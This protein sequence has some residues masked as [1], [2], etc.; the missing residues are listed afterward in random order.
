VVLL[1][2]AE[3][4]SDDADPHLSARG[5]ERAAALALRIPHQYSAPRFLFASARSHESN[6]PVETLT[7]LASALKLDIDSRWKDDD[8]EGVAAE[9]LGG[10]YGGALVAVCWHHGKLAELA[11]ALGVTPKPGAWDGAVF[12]QFWEITYGAGDAASIT[13]T[14]QKLLFGDSSR[15]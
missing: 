8:F 3:K 7:P 14:P 10:K 11:H 9:I 1:R 5:G 13:K 15:A 12:D 2:H 6:R 4:P